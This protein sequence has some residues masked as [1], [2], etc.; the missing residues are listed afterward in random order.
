MSLKW[1]IAAW[2]AALL[3][4]VLAATSGVIV[5][6]FGTIIY[7]QARD[8][9]DATMSRI[10]AV[11]KPAPLGLQD[12]SSQPLQV[13]LNGDNLAYW[14]STE[15]SI[16]IDTPGGYPLVKT[17]N[18]GQGR[19]G[20]AA[21]DAAHTTAFRNVELAG[22]PFV[23]EDRF[24]RIGRSNV[25]IHVAQSL[26]TVARAISEAR[27]TVLIVLTVAIVAVVLL[28][29]AIASQAIN[30]I[31]KLSRAMREMGFDRLDRRL[32]WRRRDDEIGELAES[33][34][35]LLARLE[36]S[37]AR[38]RQFISDASH[39]LKTPLTSI[40]ANAH[41]LLRWADRDEH[42]RRQSLETIAHESASL[43]EMVNG[44]LTLARADRQDEIP[45]EPV[46]LIEEARNVVQHAGARAQEKGL[47][48]QFDPIVDSAIVCADA[49]LIRQL[50]GNLVD[51]AIKFT[52]RG[53]I[54][55]RVGTDRANAWVE[56]RDSGPGI[57]ERDLPRIFERFYRADRSRSRSVPGAGLGLAIVR[58]IAHVHGGSVAVER[59]SS[60]G[61]LFRVTIP[62]LEGA[63]DGSFTDLS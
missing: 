15:T 33:F 59:I 52:E 21:V 56:V 60:G 26:A 18:L 11:A 31:K 20:P 25:V 43:G 51:N 27:R 22:E 30:P 28:S 55:V 34:D 36:A 3:V 9:A 46:S 41:M 23:V 48:L 62:L 8:R 63:S 47:T 37:F 19:I 35:D 32:T 16:E 61:T 57:A 39:E 2:Y 1:K 14:A 50:I 6:R 54:D 13:L 17:A 45:K 24:V 7:A 40:N 44:M 53:A 58:S 49:H 42:L 10:L 5:W 38:E 29:V 12:L 4:V